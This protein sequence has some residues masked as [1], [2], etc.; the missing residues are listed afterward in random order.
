MENNTKTERVYVGEK[1]NVVVTADKDNARYVVDLPNSYDVYWGFG[2]KVQG[3]DFAQRLE[4]T[5]PR[6]VSFAVPIDNLATQENIKTF[7]I[8]VNEARKINREILADKKDLEDVL[9]FDHAKDGKTVAFLYKNPARGFCVGEVLKAGKFFVAQSAGESDD[10]VFIRVVHTNRLLNGKD[11][12]SNREGTIQEK[13]P[14][15]SVKYL[16][17]DEHGKITAKDYQP[18]QKVEEKQEQAPAEKPVDQVEQA[19]E[20]EK[21]A[22]ELTKE[23][24]KTAEATNPEEKQTKAKSSRKKTI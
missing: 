3:Q 7:N 22:K 2:G 21:I 9:S 13:F 5:D 4:Q 10:K 6:K 23:V 11:E 20:A 18:K 19:K 1:D 14:V 12:Y 24:A 15:G 8:K 17:F 16:R